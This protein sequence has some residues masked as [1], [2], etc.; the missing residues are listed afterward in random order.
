M[1]YKCCILKADELTSTGRIYPKSV[2]DEM[3]NDIVNRL[4]D[5]K[6]FVV[7]S[8]D[9]IQSVD[10]KASIMNACGDLYDVKYIDGEIWVYVNIINSIKPGRQY[11]T[12]FGIGS[13]DNN[14]VV[15]D[16]K[17]QYLLLVDEVSYTNFS[18]MERI[19]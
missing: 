2:I 3:Y 9:E 11:I 6:I 7:D 18:K 10:F 13:V 14:N 15:L 12:S 4:K 16:C 1:K 5:E 19:D 8:D 17:L